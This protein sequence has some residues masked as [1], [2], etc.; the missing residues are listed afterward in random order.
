MCFGVVRRCVLLFVNRIHFDFRHL[1]CEKYKAPVQHFDIMSKNFLIQFLKPM[2]KHYFVIIVTK[3]LQQISGKS[4]NDVLTI[5][6]SFGIKYSKVFIF[7]FST[8]V[9]PYMAKTSGS[10]T[11]S[12]P[13]P[14]HVTCVAR[15]KHQNQT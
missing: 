6:L 7:L 10:L 11:V 3:Q 14:I 2:G 1:K 9:A 13:N 15:G 12:F 8:D 4:F 5:L